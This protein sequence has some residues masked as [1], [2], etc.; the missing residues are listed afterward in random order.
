LQAGAYGA[1]DGQ[2]FFS[3]KYSDSIERE[4][5]ERETEEGGEREI[6]EG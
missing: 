1:H 3:N 4:E 2:F 6:K 5:E